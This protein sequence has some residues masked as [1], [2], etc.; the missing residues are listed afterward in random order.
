MDSQKSFRA[1]MSS[2]F[3]GRELGKGTRGVVRFATAFDDQKHQVA[4]K[5]LDISSLER[6]YSSVGLS[7]EAS[8]EFV[9]NEAQSLSLLLG[10]PN[11]A[12]LECSFVEDSYFISCLEFIDGDDLYSYAT[13]KENEKNLQRIFFQLCTA[14][15]YCHSQKIVHGDLKCENVLIRKHDHS[16]KVIDFGYSCILNDNGETDVSGR[17]TRY[18]PPHDRNL[19]YAWDAWSIGIILFVNLKHY[20]PFSFN[21]LLSGQI[22][23]MPDVAKKAATGHIFDILVGLWKIDPLQRTQ[24]SSLL[25]ESPWLKEMDLSSHNKKRE[26]KKYRTSEEN[27]N[28]KRRQRILK[29]EKPKGKE[30]MLMRV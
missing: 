19:S 30:K 6:I 7:Q 4:M 5:I 2:W 18:S 14:I 17:I 20:F 16:V 25:N 1:R 15:A 29:K 26:T 3:V 22:P 8:R 23:E 11:I 28:H 24:I 21:Q 9:C 12:Q 27:N 13:K 10:H